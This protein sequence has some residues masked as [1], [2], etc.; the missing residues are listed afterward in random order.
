MSNS[1]IFVSM[2]DMMRINRGRSL[3][4]DCTRNLSMLPLRSRKIN[5]KIKY[6]LDYDIA[7]RSLREEKPEIIPFPV[8][9]ITIPRIV[10][11]GCWI[12][13]ALSE[14]KGLS[15]LEMFCHESRIPKEANTFS[16]SQWWQASEDSFYLKTKVRFFKINE[17]FPFSLSFS[18]TLTSIFALQDNTF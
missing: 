12:S 14:I 5:G 15:N 6:T 1:D 2:E 11:D 16:Y 17:R 10:K 7:D 4:K 8:I 13:Q 9:N 18:S 3:E